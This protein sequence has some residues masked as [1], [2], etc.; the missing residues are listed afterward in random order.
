[1]PT[2]KRQSQLAAI[3]EAIGL[4]ES[5]S[6]RGCQF[7]GCFLPDIEARGRDAHSGKTATAGEYRVCNHVGIVCHGS[8][9]TKHERFGKGYLYIVAATGEFR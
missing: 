2:S 6:Y 4:V 8:M 9:R 1:M 5:L 7:E 3:L